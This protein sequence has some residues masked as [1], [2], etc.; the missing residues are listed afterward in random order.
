MFE[1][2]DPMDK[3]SG[4]AEQLRCLEEA[5]FAGVDVP[6]ARAGQAAFCAYKPAS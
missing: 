6:W 3:P 2:P 1:H 4:T 5:G